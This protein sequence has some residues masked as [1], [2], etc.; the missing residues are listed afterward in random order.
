MKIKSTHDH[1]IFEID[2]FRSFH[3][4]NINQVDYFIEKREIGLRESDPSYY[5]NEEEE[6]VKF[7]FFIHI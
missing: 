6:K 2:D 1:W 4:S 5:Y 7:R 3:I